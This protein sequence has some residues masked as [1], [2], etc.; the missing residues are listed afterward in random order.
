MKFTL[1]EKNWRR[2]FQLAMAV[3]GFDG[4]LGMIAGTV[5]LFITKV[6]LNKDFA[7]LVGGELFEKPRDFLINYLYQLLQHL[8]VGGKTFAS[9]YILIHGFLN[10]VLVIGLYKEKLRAYWW[11]I[12]IVGLFIL[13]LLYRF[14]I[15][16]SGP[17]A[18]LIG[19]DILFILLAWREYHYN[20]TKGIIK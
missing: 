13:Y 4:I 19:F 15:T 8:S 16:H 7:I 6:R 9:I 18:L 1:S 3:K 11:A 12:G 20:K 10:I 5:L 2:F 14:I 17:T